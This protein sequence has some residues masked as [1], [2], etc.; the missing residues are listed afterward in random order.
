MH[1]QG[2]VHHRGGGGG[3]LLPVDPHQFAG[4]SG[5]HRVGSVRQ[6]ERI[7]R[8]GQ[9]CRCLF[10]HD[11][12]RGERRNEANLPRRP[13]EPCAVCWCRRSL[14]LKGRRLHMLQ[15]SMRPHVTTYATPAVPME[16][17]ASSL[18]Q[19]RG[20]RHHGYGYTGCFSHGPSLL[21]DW[22][23]RQLSWSA[24][25]GAVCLGQPLQRVLHYSLPAGLRTRAGP[26][27][28]LPRRARR[29][30]RSPGRCTHR[31]GQ[32][33]GRRLCP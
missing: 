17:G 19:R 32:T 25:S 21:S 5:E 13:V 28:P 27:A 14:D 6:E 15:E 16:R 2:R 30:V 4:C 12:L 8:K 10:P 7:K 24:G 22:T 20:A 1:N 18:R 33:T 23:E 9:E 29:G 11:R 3:L 31:G 26:G